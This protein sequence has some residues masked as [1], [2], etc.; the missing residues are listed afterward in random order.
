MDALG[1]LGMRKPMTAPPV[2]VT[3]DEWISMLAAAKEEE[4]R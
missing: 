2:T 3:H 4:I 1:L